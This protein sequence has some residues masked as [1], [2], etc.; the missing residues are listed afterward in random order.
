MP[1]TTLPLALARAQTGI[2]GDLDDPWGHLAAGY[3]HMVARRHR[4]ALDEVHEAIDR[5]PSLALAHVI[6][7]SAY[8]HGGL[9]E[10][11]LHHVAI[12]ARLGPRDYT[13]AANLS[14]A[15]L[16]HFMARRFA[17]AID[18]ERRAV[19]LRP[20]FGSAW[21]TLAAAAGLAGDR[22]AAAPG[23]GRGP[24][25]PPRPVDRLAGEIPPH[26]PRPRPRPLHPG[27]PRRRSRLV[28]VHER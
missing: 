25:R 12:A 27:P 7:A 26:R 16:C 8:A 15:G 20:N 23:P 4:P 1:A 6:L 5:N 19:Q 10:D 3:V 24:P 13:Q 28:S 9:A 17:E 11:G 22:E 14:T 2:A 21:R 18:C